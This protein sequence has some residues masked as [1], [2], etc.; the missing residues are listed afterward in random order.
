MYVEFARKS[1][2]KGNMCREHD[3]ALLGRETVV[4]VAI[5]SLS[6]IFLQAGIGEA[7]FQLQGDWLFMD[8]EST[9]TYTA[10]SFYLSIVFLRKLVTS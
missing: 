6:Y 3:R 8:E 1:R 7:N 2:P 4:H 5:C 10:P 9:H